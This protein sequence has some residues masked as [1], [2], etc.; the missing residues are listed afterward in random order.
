M[1]NR[2]SGF[3]QRLCAIALPVASV[4]SLFRSSAQNAAEGQSPKLWEQRRIILPSGCPTF[5]MPD[6]E[7]ARLILQRSIR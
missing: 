1:G 4:L 5:P 7:T 6:I 2:L 3:R